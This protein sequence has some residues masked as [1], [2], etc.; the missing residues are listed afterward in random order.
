[1]GWRVKLMQVEAVEAQKLAKGSHLTPARQAHSGIRRS[2]PG[3]HYA[4]VV[5][6]REP[7]LQVPRKRCPGRG[8]ASWVQ[9]GS[10]RSKGPMPLIAFTWV[11]P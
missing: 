1:V 9:T 2:E 8:I 11:P 4:T 7:P 5:S 6:G 10:R 3:I